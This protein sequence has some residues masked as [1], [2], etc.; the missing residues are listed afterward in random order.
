MATGPVSFAKKKRLE[1][2]LYWA[3]WHL[4][5][6]LTIE[7]KVEFTFFINL[8]HPIFV[9]ELQNQFFFTISTFKQFFYTLGSFDDGFAKELNWTKLKVH[10]G[11]QTK[12]YF[13]K[14]P[15]FHKNK[16]SNFFLNIFL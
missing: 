15:K 3:A 9:H 10:G 11:N 8:S 1:P 5:R 4:S 16:F 2:V 12:K 13:K 14:Y 6:S 7:E